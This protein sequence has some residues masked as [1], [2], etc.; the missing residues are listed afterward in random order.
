MRVGEPL[1][2]GFARL[3]PRVRRRVLHLLGRYAPWEVEFDFASP[4]LGPGESP[5]PPSFVGIGA[6]KAGTTWWYELMI[7]HPGISARDDIHKERHFFDRFGARAMRAPDIDQY[8]GWFPRPAGM[9]TGEWTPDYLAFPWVPELLHRA[10]PDTR[11][12][13]LLRDPVERFRSGLDH[14]RAMGARRD[15]TAIADAVQRGFYSRSLELWM[16]HFGPEQLL[17]LQYERCIVD[18]DRQLDATFAHLG[19]APHHPPVSAQPETT[20]DRRGTLD[21]EVREHLVSLYAADV[22]SLA[23][24][25]PAIDLTLWPNFAYLTGSSGSPGS[26]E[27][28]P[29][30]RP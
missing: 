19:L 30:R 2:S 17:V 16:D 12:L 6:Q 1:R 29:N 4:P 23:A 20:R 22:A 26:D 11:L 27:N 8:H 28:S 14:L 24:S 5:G 10:A 9:L 7:T 13:V 21:D 3:P 25:H 18:R 15:G